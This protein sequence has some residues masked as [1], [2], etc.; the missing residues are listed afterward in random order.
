[1]KRNLEKCWD[2]FRKTFDMKKKKEATESDYIMADGFVILEVPFA[3]RDQ[4]KQ[5]LMWYEHL[6][7]S[8]HVYHIS[9]SSLDMVTRIIKNQGCMFTV[10]CIED[11]DNFE[12]GIEYNAFDEIGGMYLVENMAGIK[13]HVDCSKFKKI[14]GG[15]DD[16][17]T[18]AEILSKNKPVAFSKPFKSKMER[19]HESSVTA[20]YLHKIFKK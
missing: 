17:G 13:E 10:E 15:M 12:K 18:F 1:M 6:S 9:S 11:V 2:E 3:D 19:D 4:Y 20:D 8:N 16:N 14:A 7:K 5:M